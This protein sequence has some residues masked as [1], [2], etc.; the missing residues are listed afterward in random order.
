MLMNCSYTKSS[1]CSRCVPYFRYYVM[2]ILMLYKE[3]DLNL[4]DLG[5]NIDTERTLGEILILINT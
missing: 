3:I 4:T 2:L 5:K 1:K